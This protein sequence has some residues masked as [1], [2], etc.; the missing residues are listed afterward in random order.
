MTNYPRDIGTLRRS[1]I[2]GALLYLPMF[3]VGT[4]YLAVLLVSALS[5]SREYADLVGPADLV[6][7]GINVV[8]LGAI[9]FRFLSGQFRR[10]T[11]RG[12]RLFG[13][14]ALG[15]LVYFGLAMLASRVM[16]ILQTL[17]RIEYQ[18]ANQD[19]VEDMLRLSPLISLIT[20][21]VLAPI[22]EELVF[23]GLVFCGLY[24]KSRT[25]AYALSMLSFSLSHVA[26]SMFDQSVGITLLN[27]AAYLPHGFALAWV[28][29][30]SGSIWSSVFLHSAINIFATLMFTLMR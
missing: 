4:P 21:C 7:A 19:A 16:G 11:D 14:V 29:E 25:L 5:G 22:G 12:W 28:Y 20:V 1:E 10:I 17:F 24:Q 8:A 26:V 18:N 6:Y 13:D 30:R 2:I 23:R 27:L 15:F 3:L 9:L